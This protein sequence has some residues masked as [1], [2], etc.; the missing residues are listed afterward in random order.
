MT[1]VDGTFQINVATDGTSLGFLASITGT[2]ENAL[3]SNRGICDTKRGACDPGV[4]PL[5]YILVAGECVCFSGW[6]SSD[7]SGGRGGR[8]DCG[9]IEPFV[10]RGEPGKVKTYYHGVIYDV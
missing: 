9:Y 5:Q 6:G 7:S 4:A 8:G 2:Q 10:P 3:C 1:F